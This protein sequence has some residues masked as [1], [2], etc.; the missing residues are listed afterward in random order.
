MYT[1]ESLTIVIPCFN[2]ATRLPKTLESL[3]TYCSQQ[4]YPSTLLVVDDGSTDGLLNQVKQ[5]ANDLP[6]D[7]RVSIRWVH[8]QQNR[9]KGEAVRQ[10]VYATQTEWLLIFDADGATPID[11]LEAFWGGI[12]T[13]TE[14]THQS[15]IW[16]GQRNWEDIGPRGWGRAWISRQF[17]GLMHRLLPGVNDSQCGFKLLTTSLATQLAGVQQVQGFTF[18]VEWLHA[19]QQNGGTVIELPVPWHDQPGSKV[20]YIQDGLKALFNLYRISQRSKQGAYRFKEPAI[21]A[22]P[23]VPALPPIEETP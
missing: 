1:P 21:N 19:L 2:E 10:G 6:A 23:F 5:R 14:E 9:G 3:I 7:S 15:A 16:I 8:L 18:D 4:V 22:C 13:H 17:V 11:A 20:R 12:Q